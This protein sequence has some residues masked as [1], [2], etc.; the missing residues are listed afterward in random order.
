M[1]GVG[2]GVDCRP[3]ADGPGAGGDRPGCDRA[4][5]LDHDP[6]ASR[7]GHRFLHRRRLAGAGGGDDRGRGAARAVRGAGP[8]DRD[9]AVAAGAN[10]RGTVGAALHPDLV[11][12]AGTGSPCPPRDRADGIGATR[13][14][15]RPG[16]ARAAYPGR[17]VRCPRAA[18]ADQLVGQPV[19]PSAWADT[20]PGRP[21]GG[22]GARSPG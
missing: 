20:A 10:R 13:D 4:D 9:R 15:H 12:L 1:G 7:T 18:I 5:R 8:A 3:D 22:A 2:R 16:R 21:A 17:P 11:S 6:G 14:D 19:D